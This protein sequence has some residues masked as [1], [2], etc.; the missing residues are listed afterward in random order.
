MIIL[1]ICFNFIR[2]YYYC[3]CYINP[4][5]DIRFNKIP[6]M[7]RLRSKVNAI[8]KQRGNDDGDIVPALHDDNNIIQLKSVPTVSHTLER[9]DYIADCDIED[10]DQHDN[11]NDLTLTTA[12][13][14]DTYQH[15]NTWYD[16]FISDRNWYYC[17]SIWSRI[18]KHNST[19]SSANV[20]DYI[21]GYTY[22]SPYGVSK[23]SEINQV[24]QRSEFISKN[25]KYLCRQTFAL[26]IGYDG[27]QY[28]GYQ[29]QK[30]FNGLTVEEDIL[31]IIKLPTT[32][33]GRTDRGVS[34]ISQ[35]I[36]FNTNNMNL[37]ANDIY[38]K[39]KQSKPCLDG[40]L[41]IYDCYRVP[42]KFHSRASAIWRRYLYMFPLKRL[43]IDE[44]TKNHNNNDDNSNDDNSNDDNSNDD[45]SNN[46][47]NFNNINDDVDKVDSFQQHSNNCDSSEKIEITDNDIQ[48][49]TDKYDVDVNYLNI[50][51]SKLENRDLP[52]NAFAFK[53]DRV[54]GKGF[55]YFSLYDI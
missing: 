36:N 44:Y 48:K 47:N 38:N 8:D 34:A 32:G 12:I 20:P 27:Q 21:E 14:T 46:E 53:E 39:F 55:E 54:Q 6:I 43:S 19:I 1:T 18:I 50:V 28:Y 23:L 26:R 15:I 17:E 35:I 25:H 7:K 42:K 29:R 16:L 13:V 30:N 37:T 31:K 9:S 22:D 10:V 40:R 51:L 4:L 41:T 3:S 5:V 24:G 45:N 2:S 52:Y 49:V 33:A 11:N